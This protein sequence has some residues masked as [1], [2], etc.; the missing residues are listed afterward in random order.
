MCSSDLYPGKRYYGGCEFVDL[1]EQLAIDRLKELYGAKFANVQAN[2]GSQANQAVFLALPRLP[3]A[4]RDG[5]TW[6]DHVPVGLV[7][8]GLRGALVGVA[9]SVWPQ[10]ARVRVTARFAG[11]SRVETSVES[12]AL[13]VQ[14]RGFATFD[15]NKGFATLG[16]DGWEFLRRDDA[17]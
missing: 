17:K 15:R 11:E 5:L 8:R 12:R 6:Q 10:L 1:A 4:C 14:E 13:G 2:S 7:A 16:Y 3:L 9:S